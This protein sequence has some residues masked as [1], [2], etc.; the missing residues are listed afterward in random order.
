MGK[1][2]LT[3]HTGATQ[4]NSSENTYSQSQKNPGFSSVL[5]VS[6]PEMMVHCW[7]VKTTRSLW[8]EGDAV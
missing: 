7:M 5:R 4:E 3:D 2:I 8:S 1:Q 6:P